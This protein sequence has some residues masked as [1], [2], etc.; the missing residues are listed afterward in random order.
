M[1]IEVFKKRARLLWKPLNIKILEILYFRKWQTASEIASFLGI[2][3]STAVKYLSEF[4]EVRILEKRMRESKPRKSMEYKL[5]DPKIEI[6]LS[7][8]N[9]IEE[10]E[11]IIL[12]KSKKIHIRE[13]KDIDASFEWNEKREVI[14]KIN[15][16]VSGQRRIIMDFLELNEIEGKFLWNLPYPSEDF[17]SV[18]EICKKA[19]LSN[20]LEIEVCL[21][22]VEKLEN[23]LVEVRD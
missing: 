20:P 3:I 18:F 21:K 7:L 2:H 17:K 14:K 23:E 11:K 4:E 9:L 22:L 13:K 15:F 16:M 19:G 10:E 12:K 6:T 1:E 5:I 8:K